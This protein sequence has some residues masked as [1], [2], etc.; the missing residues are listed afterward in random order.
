MKFTA[1]AALVMTTQAVRLNQ[2]STN[3]QGPSDADIEKYAKSIIES[4]DTDGDEKVSLD[5]FLT[6]SMKVYDDQMDVMEAELTNVF[7]K[8]DADGNGEVD[9]EE[10]INTF[11]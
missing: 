7:N 1:I 11:K 2:L 9:L 6:K 4:M 10:I 8:V 3:G 5:E